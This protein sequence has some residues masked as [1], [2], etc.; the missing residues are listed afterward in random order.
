[1]DKLIETCIRG[2]IRIQDGWCFYSADFS[3]TD[4]G[5]SAIGE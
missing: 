1:M 5:K 4:R 3:Y 2:G